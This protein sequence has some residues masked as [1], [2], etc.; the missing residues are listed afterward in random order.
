MYVNSYNF[1]TGA[2]N[3]GQYFLPYWM[4]VCHECDLMLLFGFPWMPTYMLPAHLRNVRWTD[5][6]RNMSEVFMSMWAQ[7]AKKK[8][9]NL[10]NDN[11]WFNY[12][13]RDHWYLDLNVTR[14]LQKDFDWEHV[15]FWNVYMEQLALLV[16]TTFSPTMV[17][18]RKELIAFKAVSGT[19]IVLCCA[20]LTVTAAMCYML[21]EKRKRRKFKELR[22]GNKNS[23]VKYQ[24]YDPEFART[25]SL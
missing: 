20:A 13:P 19:F 6:D 21:F 9:P 2:L 12:A 4:C 25:S 17:A 7:F 3:P 18:M 22:A 10:P 24:E 16:T 14:R 23:T 11:Q 8:D 1:S 5:Y 15:A